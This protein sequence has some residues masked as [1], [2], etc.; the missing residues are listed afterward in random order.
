MEGKEA[1]RLHD[2]AAEVSLVAVSQS[3]ASW[4]SKTYGI[5]I[6][7]ISVVHN[8]VDLDEFHPRDGFLRPT[9]PVRVICHGRIDPNKGHDIA[10]RAVAAL[11]AKGLPVTFTMVGAVQTF[12]IPEAEERAFAEELAAATAA[13]EGT[14][15]GRIPADQVAAVLREHDIAC[16]LSKSEEPFSLSAL[17]SM[18]SGCAVITTGRGGIKEATGDAAVIVGVDDVD[19][20]ASAIES[21]IT[22]RLFLAERKASARARADSFTWDKSA[23]ALESLIDA[24]VRRR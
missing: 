23:H 22:D 3:V 9:S 19:A 11:R 15:T 2:L 4:T 17:E 20:V 1:Q 13:A 7:A 24:A 12:G 8:G 14:S 16:V 6:E 10:A 5:P 18:A 21:L